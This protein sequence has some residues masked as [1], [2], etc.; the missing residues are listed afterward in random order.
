M[1]IRL[2]LS[3]PRDA[4]YVG[5]LRSVTACMLE[6]VRAPAPA[7]DDLQVAL[8]EAC[9]NVI[10]H[11]TGSEEYSV[12]LVMGD[13]GCE[14]EVVDVGPGFEPPSLEDLEPPLASEEGRGLLLMDALV[15]R[16]EFA[17]QREGTRLRLCKRWDGLKLPPSGVADSEGV[18]AG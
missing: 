13:A 11:A 12:T 4:R 14:V 3:L 17:D 15:D 16:L 1:H 7:A 2:E 18:G 5:T 10:R 6:D 8:S 9:N